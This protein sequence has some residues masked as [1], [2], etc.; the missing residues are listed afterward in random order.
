VNSES[1][2]HNS[3]QAPRRGSAWKPIRLAVLTLITLILTISALAT[4]GGTQK[5]PK[6]IN[7]CYGCV[8]GGDCQPCC[9]STYSAALNYCNAQWTDCK[10]GCSLAYSVCT[11]NC[12]S[13]DQSCLNAC[14]LEKQDCNSVCGQ[15]NNG[16]T[17]DALY[18][19]QCCTGCCT[20][21]DLCE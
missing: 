2:F 15:N 11:A 1:H 4:S 7:D 9:S 20:T 12:A 21:G 6:V 19:Y 5:T 16:C 14:S 17:S 10:S 18:T 8:P 3:P 13:G